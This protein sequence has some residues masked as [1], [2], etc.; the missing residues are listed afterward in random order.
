MGLGL[1]WLSSFGHANLIENN[2]LHELNAPILNLLFLPIIIF[3]SGWSLRWK[4]FAAQL[5]YVLVFAVFGSLISTAVVGW[6]IHATGERG[7]HAV[8][9]RRTAYAFASLIAATDP[10]ATLATYSQL[11][12]DPL[13]NVMVFGESTINDAVAIVIFEILNSDTVFGGGCNNAGPTVNIWREI[14]LGVLQ[15][16]FG[17]MV[18]GFALAALYTLTLRFAD[19]THS[20]LMEILFI[21]ISSYLTFSLAE[22]V[23]CSGIITVLFCSMAMGIYTKPHLSNEGK[24]LATFVVKGAATL[25]DTGVFLLVGVD[26]IAT[27]G[28]S[29]R[30]SLWVM[31]FCITGRAVAVFPLGLLVNLG[32]SLHGRSQGQPRDRWFL[33]SWQHLL[34]MWHAG[35]RGG[36]ALV[37]CLE[38]GDW[39]DEAGG[40]GTK[41]VLINTTIVVI[42]VFLLV[43]GGSTEC[44][45]KMLG[46]SMGQDLPEDYLYSASL[47]TCT[48]SCGSYLRRQC[49]WPLLVGT[50]LALAGSDLDEEL[51]QHQVSEM[52]QDLQA[53][54]RTHAFYRKG[55]R[56][57]PDSVPMDE[58]QDW[59]DSSAEHD[60]DAQRP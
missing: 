54:H 59:S 28:P 43:L 29:L 50:P 23:H 20:Q 31:L 2:L 6:L 55:A 57:L 27:N 52:L 18:L 22:A 8:A 4:D 36:I 34:M 5:Q 42:C 13:L 3:E 26:V 17:S 25:A 24:L 7:Y 49:L 30:F 21:L 45:L 48:R 53:A 19:L 60:S 10:V 35:L 14:A 58:D 47:L 12:V 51:P 11:R 37:L 1:I 9:D 32:K 46:I 40:A 41:Q 15:K 39:V 44:C 16:L 33:L 38:L 56:L